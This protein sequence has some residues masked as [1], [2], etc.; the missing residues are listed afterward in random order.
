MLYIIYVTLRPW[1]LYY[2]VAI[3]AEFILDSLL[4]SLPHLR[5]SIG[6]VIN[7]SVG[8]CRVKLISEVWSY[9]PWFAA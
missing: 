3:L 4:L 7:E 1:D 6:L 2:L 8:F 5:R 9:L